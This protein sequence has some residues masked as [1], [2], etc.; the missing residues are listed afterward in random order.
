MKDASHGT[1]ADRTSQLT[2]LIAIGIVLAATVLG[3]TT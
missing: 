1:R 2:V 3:R